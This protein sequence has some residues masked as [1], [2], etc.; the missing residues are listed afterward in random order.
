[1]EKKRA[2]CG[3]EKKI[4]IKYQFLMDHH[5]QQPQR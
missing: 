4:E 2:K 1:M 5:D 3:K